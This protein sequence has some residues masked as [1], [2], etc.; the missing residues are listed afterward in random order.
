LLDAPKSG[1]LVDTT[2]V[3]LSPGQTVAIQSQHNFQ[4]DV[5]QFAL[6]AN[7]FAKLAV[8]SVNLAS[9]TIYVRMGLDP[10]CGFRSFATGIPTS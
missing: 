9:R 4:G 6:N 8:D 1:Y 3:V 5:C 10:N 2:A 7:I